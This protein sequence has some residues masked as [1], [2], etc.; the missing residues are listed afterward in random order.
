MRANYS[1]SLQTTQRLTTRNLDFVGTDAAGNLIDLRTGLPFNPATDAFS[2]QTDTFRQRRFLATLTGKRKRN[3]FNF[4]GFWEERKTDRTGAD[5]TV[6]GV[7]ANAARTLSRRTTGDV[8]LTYRKS[9]FEGGTN[10][11][12]HLYAVTG[13]LSYEMFR[14]TSAVLSYS[15]TQR[16]SSVDGNDVTENSVVLGLRREF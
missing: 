1:D 14:N 4:S 9:E 2:V 5:D 12:D 8:S 15:R 10:R 3:T 13:K 6:I 16:K 11:T 7:A